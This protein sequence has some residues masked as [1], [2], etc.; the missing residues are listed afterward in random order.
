MKK[1]IVLL[2]ILFVSCKKTAVYPIEEPQNIVNFF[3]NEQNTV[4][5]GSQ[6]T[7]DLKNAGT[8][9]MTM[10]DSTRNQVV[11]REKISGKIGANALKIYTKSLNSKYLYLLLKDSVGNQIGKTLLIIK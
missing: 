5:D 8:Y 6:V 9:T 4:T 10:L 7:F 2:L 3:D 11:T 1:I